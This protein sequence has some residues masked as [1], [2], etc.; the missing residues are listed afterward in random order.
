MLSTMQRGV[1]ENHNI[2]VLTLAPGC[3]S[4][5]T[6]HSD[7]VIGRGDTLRTAH[8]AKALPTRPHWCALYAQL[9][10]P[11]PPPS[12]WGCFLISRSAVFV[13]LKV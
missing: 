12:N 11:C 6:T 3:P 2:A 8:A 7:A 5:S 10:T 4:N 1:W 9:C 13:V